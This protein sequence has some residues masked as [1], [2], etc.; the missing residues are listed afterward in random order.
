MFS[1]KSFK[2][3]LVQSLIS[4]GK[5]TP[6]NLFF[7]L[8]IS[9]SLEAITIGLE[10]LEESFYHDF[11]FY[12]PCVSH[13]NSYILVGWVLNSWITFVLT[14]E[15]FTGLRMVLAEISW[16]S[17]FICFTK[18]WAQFLDSQ[19]RYLG[20]RFNPPS[21]S[22]YIMLPPKISI[23]EDHFIFPYNTVIVFF[24]SHQFHFNLYRKE[25]NTDRNVL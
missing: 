22:E 11:H 15:V 21:S 13:W 24:K 1:G 23:L 9:F 12:F 10:I 25:E 19:V 2:G 18:D 17:C 20:I 5:K 14:L 6:Y 4:L 8:Y 7:P 3:S 16:K